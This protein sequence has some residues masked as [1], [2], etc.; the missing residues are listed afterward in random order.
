MNA[1]LKKILHAFFSWPLL[2]YPLQETREDA[3][4][5]EEKLAFENGLRIAKDYYHLEE[6][7]D[8][9]EITE[10]VLQSDDTSQHFKQLILDS[11]RRFIVF[12]YP[13]D[14]F[15]VKGLLSFVPEPSTNPLLIFLR[16][17][18]RLHSLQD[19]ATD[20]LCIRNYTII[21]TTYRGGVSEGTDEYGGNDVNDVYNLMAYFPALQEK[22]DL[23][24]QPSKIF[25]LGASRGGMQAFL[26]LSRF[27]SL[28]NMVHK[29]ASLSGLLDMNECILD[30]EDMK[31]MFIDDFGLL[32]NVN[33]EEWIRRRNPLNAVADI[34]KDLPFLIIQGTD[35]QRV[36]LIEGYNMVSRLEENGN[37]V[38]YIEIPGGTH[39]LRN[40]KDRMDI[41]ADWFESETL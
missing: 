2:I 33:E 16:G 1:Y 38:T 5:K 11:G 25:M 8:Y 10:K 23:H 24:F 15:Q 27:T 35:D 39:C 36:G 9:N 14:G 3:L 30:R 32:P 17:G 7:R 26:S 6:G 41:I 22:L 40:Q 31:E 29:A 4:N 19:P 18:N 28:Q 37:P 20:Y 34:R 12:S 13:S 21:T